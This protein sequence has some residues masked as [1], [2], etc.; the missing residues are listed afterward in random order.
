MKDSLGS[1]TEAAQ[2]FMTT[3]GP[4]LETLTRRLSECPAEFLEEPIQ[5]GQGAVHVDAVVSDLVREL[6]GDPL[7][8]AEA[9]DFRYPGC[10]RNRL[11]INLVVV[12][13]LRDR[14]FAGQPGIAA[15]VTDLLTSKQIKQLSSVV[16]APDVVNDPDRREEL[17]RLCLAH[18]HLRPAGETETDA[19][20]RLT[21]LDSVER[22]GVAQA[23]EQAERRAR[24]LREEI[25]RKAREEEAA[26]KVSRE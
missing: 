8:P 2:N 17:V 23:A 11:R 16:A 1:V 20:D 6:G 24:K 13:L 4:L 21:A 25:A 15:Q 22:A 5:P 12:W 19:Q 18:L 9:S 26:A 3:E 14:W 7:S 10:G